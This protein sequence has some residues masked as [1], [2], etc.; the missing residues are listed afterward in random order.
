MKNEIAL[1]IKPTMLCNMKCKHC[2]NGDTLDSAEILDAESAC[3]AIRLAC[4]SYEN[5]KITFHGG[6]PSLAGYDF[7]IKIFDCKRNLEKEFGTKFRFFFTTNGVL[8]GGALL[9]LLIQNDVVLNISY[10]GPC[11]DI[12]RENSAL[13]LNNILQAK[14]K[15]AKIRIF[16]TLSKGSAERLM[17]IYEWF[18]KENL[19]FK[20]L[21]IEK[22]GYAECKSQLIMKPE[23][24]VDNFADVYKYWLKDKEN[25]IHFYTFEEFASL[26][27]TK[28]FKPFLFN[29]E[30]A[31]NPNGKLYP[32]G[33]PNDIQFEL[34]KI[35]TLEDL[36]SCFNSRM[37]QKLL[38]RLYA[39]QDKFCRCCESKGVCNGVV[40]CMSYMYVESEELLGYSCRQSSQIFSEI[41]KINDSVIKDIKSGNTQLYSEFAINK[42]KDVL[43]GNKE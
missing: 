22:R 41:L 6:E 3:K 23:V 5:V 11:N 32:F 9:D 7:Y 19:N 25:T 17:E 29:R 28:Q 35:D 27:R 37:Y 30:I 2:F 4:K 20:T 43:E 24:L 38:L 15:G 26:R 1:T 14:K 21:P 12:L 33:R 39:L 16:C 34:A 42:F 36:E 40:I 31:L 13:V 8:L 10:D 18:K